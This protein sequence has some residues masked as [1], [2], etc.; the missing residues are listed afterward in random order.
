[1]SDEGID[2]DEL[3]A[4]TN[5]STM[6]DWVVESGGTYDSIYSSGHS[7]RIAGGLAPSD[8]SCI[9][10]L[11]NA[12]PAL[13]DMARRTEQV[14]RV[15]REAYAEVRRQDD[16]ATDAERE[17]DAADENLATVA[18]TARRMRRERDVA[19]AALARV[20][21]DSMVEKIAAAIADQQACGSCADAPPYCAACTE[22]AVAALGAIRKAAQ[23]LMPE[24]LEEE[25]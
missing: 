15:A 10:A 19:Q 4:H 5:W 7:G 18:A 12:A 1:M 9:A 11:H 24:G 8:A 13:I 3:A 23:P 2:L 20:T 16:R 25:L 17:R 6:G 14:E 21:D 22:E